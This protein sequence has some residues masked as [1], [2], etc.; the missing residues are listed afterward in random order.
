MLVSPTARNV[1]KGDDV[2]EVLRHLL[3]HEAQGHACRHVPPED[4]RLQGARWLPGLGPYA[5]LKP[6]VDVFELTGKVS[7]ASKSAQELQP[8]SVSK[9]VL[10]HWILQAPGHTCMAGKDEAPQ[11]HRV[12]CGATA[13]RLGTMHALQPM[14]DG[15]TWQLQSA[16]GT[17]VVR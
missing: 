10:V 12:G 14:A 3:Q 17:L 2:S 6:C 8:M 7:C 15:P 13:S 5:C 9:F 4:R 1:P 11:W 16:Q